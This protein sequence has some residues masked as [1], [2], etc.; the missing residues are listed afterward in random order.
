MHIDVQ[1]LRFKIDI[2][3]VQTIITKKKKDEGKLQMQQNCDPDR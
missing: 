2:I 1:W 3:I